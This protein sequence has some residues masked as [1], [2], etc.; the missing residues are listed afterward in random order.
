MVGALHIFIKYRADGILLELSLLAGDDNVALACKGRKQHPVA[1]F[2]IVVQLVLLTR[3]FLD[4]HNRAAMSHTCGYAHQNGQVNL[5]GIAEGI[6]HHV[7]GFLLAAGLECGNHRK[8]GIE[9]AVLLVLRGMHRRVVGNKYHDA[10]VGSRHS[11][12]HERVGT[13]VESH[14]LHAYEG[15]LAHVRHTEGGFHSRLLVGRPSAVH[16]AL[17]GQW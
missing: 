13:H 1:G 9:A 4:F 5:L 14:M 16:V 17:F 8:L 6:L 2:G 12:I 3:G 10:S 11:G 7:V 15:T